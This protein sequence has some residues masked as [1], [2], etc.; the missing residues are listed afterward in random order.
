[1]VKRALFV[2]AALASCTPRASTFPATDCPAC[3]REK[4]SGTRPLE[5]DGLLGARWVELAVVADTHLTLINGEPHVHSGLGFETAF[6]LTRD[7]RWRFILDADLTAGAWGDQRHGTFFWEHSGGLRFTFTNDPTILDGYVFATGGFMMGGFGNTAGTNMEIGSST[8]GGVGVRVFRFIALEATSHWEYAA[9]T[10]FAAHD[11]TRTQHALDIGLGVRIDLCAFGSACTRKP[12]KQKV[13]D[14]TC[15]LYTVAKGVCARTADR[16]ALCQT[17]ASAI[18]VRED[19]A[20]ILA[21]DAVSRFLDALN[22]PSLRD[23]NTCLDQ[24]RECGREQERY[25]GRQDA[26]V[27]VRRMY[28]PYVL[29]LL[30]ALG[31]QTNGT[32][33]PACDYACEDPL[34]DEQICPK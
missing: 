3:A 23:A 8:G 22:V 10:P 15:G 17:A 31:C 19:T 11:G 12:R 2:I 20:P 1:V 4:D 21:R 30:Q 33:T 27:D 28:S 26:Q 5:S 9:G 14:R 18:A 34:P 25:F 7:D 24:W 16:A 29:E 6:A 13:V 32:P